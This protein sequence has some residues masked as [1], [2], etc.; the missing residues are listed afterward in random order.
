MDSCL[1]Q[2]HLLQMKCKQPYPGSEMSPTP[3]LMMITI[4]LS[5]LPKPQAGCK[6]IFQEKYNFLLQDRLLYQG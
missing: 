6:S 2:V 5:V 3:F 4:A 1:L